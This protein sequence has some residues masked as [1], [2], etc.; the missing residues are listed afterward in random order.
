MP[1]YNREKYVREAIDSVLSQTFTDFELFAIDDGSTDGSTEI[2]KSYGS[3]I[4]LIQQCNHGPE[5]ARNKAAALAQG[6][7]LSFFDSDDFLFPNALAIYDRI[8]REF[9][10]PPVIIGSEIF[11]REG[12]PIP[13]QAFAPRPVKVF[14]YRDYL[15]KTVSVTGVTSKFLI[16]KSVFDE[17]GGMRNS[18]AQTFHNDDLNILLKTGTHGPCIIM[19][20]PYT[21]GYRVHEGN[22]LKNIEV[23]AEGVLSLARSERLGEYPGGSGRLWDRY[24]LLGGRA[25]TWAWKYCWRN[26]QRKLAIQLLLGTA[27]MVFASVCSKLLRYVRKPPQPTVL[28]EQ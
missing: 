10:S 5:V 11:F 3:R 1:V 12:K 22:S 20:A 6:E 21:V 18:T 15:S 24:V 14:T 2:L 17:V 13:A 4:K 28:P 19:Q 25:S 26:R 9:D 8:I 23:T 27:P 16:R 7:Y